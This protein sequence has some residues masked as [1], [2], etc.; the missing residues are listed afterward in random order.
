[1]CEK[2]ESV[3]LEMMWQGAAKPNTAPK[4]VWKIHDIG[5]DQVILEMQGKRKPERFLC[6]ES[7]LGKCKRAT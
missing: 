2:V 1:M 4:L 3:C 7:M 6:N 5:A